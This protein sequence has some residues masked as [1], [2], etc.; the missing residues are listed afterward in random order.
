M[1]DF[2]HFVIFNLDF[3]LALLM[4]QSRQMCIVRLLLNGK[5]DVNHY[6]RNTISNLQSVLYTIRKYS[7][8]TVTYVM[9][10]NALQLHVLL[11]TPCLLGMSRRQYQ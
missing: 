5:S 9:T 8:Q 6:I 1:E 3:D 4:K 11:F 7:L 10:A 2:Q